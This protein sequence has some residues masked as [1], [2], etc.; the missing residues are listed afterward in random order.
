MGKTPIDKLSA[1]VER[2]LTEYAEDTTKTVDDL[3]VEM[4]KKGA[5]ALKGES[6]GAY[7]GGKYSRGWKVTVEESR[8]GTT[9]V[10]HNTTPG[11]PHLLEHGHAKRNGGRVAGRVHI[12][13]VEEKI[14]E[15]FKKAV[16]K[17][18]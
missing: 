16:S 9:A 7:G 18:L 2:I 10:I 12:A 17:A 11:L 15:E 4:A 5:K 8:L 13:P 3:A 6:A 14:V 1:E